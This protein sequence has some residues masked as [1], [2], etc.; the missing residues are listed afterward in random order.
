MKTV[1]SF[2]ALVAILAVA[3]VFVAAYAERILSSVDAV[4]IPAEE[5]VLLFRALP[6]EIARMSPSRRVSARWAAAAS[7][8]CASRVPSLSDTVGEMIAD[9][10]R[11]LA[12]SW[13]SSSISR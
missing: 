7:P 8:T 2:I 13:R 12:A 3:G 9:C 4:D 11:P 10:T 1:L 6:P 5:R